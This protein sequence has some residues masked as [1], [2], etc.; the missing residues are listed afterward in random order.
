MSNRQPRDPR[1]KDCG[2]PRAPGK[3]RCERHLGL[4]NHRSSMRRQRL[5]RAGKCWVCQAPVTMRDRD[6]PAKTCAKHANYFADR[7]HTRRTARIAI[8]G[9]CTRA[10]K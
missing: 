4:A 9:T 10:K 8:H 5:E 1:C 6:T 3:A 2:S 7:D